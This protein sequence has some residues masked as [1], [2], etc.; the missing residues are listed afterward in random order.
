MLSSDPNKQGN[1]ES[2]KILNKLLSKQKK[3]ARKKTANIV[4]G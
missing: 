3:S 2:A 4:V 1:D